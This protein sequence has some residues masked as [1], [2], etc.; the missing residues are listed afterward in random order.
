MSK[1]YGSSI[2]HSADALKFFRRSCIDHTQWPAI[3][4]FAVIDI[5]EKAGMFHANTWN[6]RSNLYYSMQLSILCAKLST[7]SKANEAN[8]HRTVINIIYIDCQK[9]YFRCLYVAVCGRATFN[10]IQIK[11]HI[12]GGECGPEFNWNVWKSPNVF[13]AE[14]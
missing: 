13:E 10:Q 11:V 4:I 3:D 8:L 6:L 1:N 7:F 9:E 14:N 2:L 5:H 12:N